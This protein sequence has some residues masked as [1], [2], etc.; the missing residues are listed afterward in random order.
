MSALAIAQ[1]QEYEELLTNDPLLKALAEPRQLQ[2][3][4]LLKDPESYRGIPV[5]LELAFC[6]LGKLENPF[7]TRF[8]M[9]NYINFACW[10]GQAMLWEREQYIDSFPLF[11]ADRRLKVSEVFATAMPFE[12]FEV[13]AIIRDTFRGLPWVEILSA[14]PL[15]DRLTKASVRHIRQAKLQ[16]AKG[17]HSLA[18]GEFA[19]A[20]KAP[21][22]RAHR[23]IVLKMA[24]RN[25]EQLGNRSRAN[26]YWGEAY[27][28]DP[29]DPE[30][31]AA[32]NRILKSGPED[33][34]AAASGQGQPAMRVAPIPPEQV[35]NTPPAGEANPP[36]EPPKG[37]PDKGSSAPGG[38]GGDTR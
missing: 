3:E 36:A 32:Y 25:Q 2:V 14:K 19:R 27:A 38:D 13:H 5:R 33:Q 8:T 20:L 7:F 37:E 31:R 34:R 15:E 22:P 9:A 24:A 18:A 4:D 30:V 21:L 6:G 10:N 17:N 35:P 16:L 23:L 29:H 1:K 26:R 28:L 11:F 12:R